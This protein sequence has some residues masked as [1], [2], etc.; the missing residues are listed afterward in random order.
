[1]QNV[2]AFSSNE[3]ALKVVT[4]DKLPTKSMSTWKKYQLP[5]RAMPLIP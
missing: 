1:M 2:V 3:A 5:L 4:I